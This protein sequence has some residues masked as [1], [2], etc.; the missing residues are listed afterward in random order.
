MT[1]EF[2][3][4][5]DFVSGGYFL[6]QPFL[7]PPDRHPQFMPSSSGSPLLTLSQC[8]AE[9]LPD[10]WAFMTWLPTPTRESRE[11]GAREWGIPSAA[12]D[13]LV[14]WAIAQVEG[15]RVHHHDSFADVETAREFAA[16]Y[17]RLP[18]VRLVG[19]GLSGDLVAQYLRDVERQSEVAGGMRGGPNGVHDAVARWVLMEPGGRALGYEVLDVVLGESRHSWHCH[20]VERQMADEF[21]IRPGALGLFERYVDAVRVADWCNDNEV[22]CGPAVWRAWRVEEYDLE[23][24]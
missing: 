1:S 2:T 5:S 7:P 3:S 18:G 19:L 6:V 20:D 15:G 11:S 22:G 17:V 24:R 8:L 12:I 4:A 21:G 9:I 23:G 16:R 13:E 14:A 10:E